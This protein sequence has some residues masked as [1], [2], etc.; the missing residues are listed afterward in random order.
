MRDKRT[1][2]ISNFYPYP[3]FSSGPRLKFYPSL[4]VLWIGNT[5]VTRQR[6]GMAP[7]INL[8]EITYWQWSIST[9]MKVTTL[10]YQ[11]SHQFEKKTNF[12]SLRTWPL[13]V[14]PVLIPCH[15]AL[16]FKRRYCSNLNL[17]MQ[18]SRSQM[19]NNNVMSASKLLGNSDMSK[20]VA[21]VSWLLFRGV[22]RSNATRSHHLQMWQYFLSR[23]KADW[24][25]QE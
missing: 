25:C 20:L 7:P 14:Q 13:A 17:K 24:L 16:T 1:L 4:N 11:I 19:N 9:H 2:H 23:S 8:P 12:A 22:T 3:S 21:L 6:V 18:D 5:A 15:P 10:C